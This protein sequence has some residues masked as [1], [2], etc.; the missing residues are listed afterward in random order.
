MPSISTHLHFGKVLLE[1]NKDIDLLNFTIGLVAPETIYDNLDDYH[2]LDEDGNIDVREFY[3]K[4]N[5]K[6]LSLEA[7]SFILGYYSNLWLEEYYKFNA[8]KL[9]VHNK[10]ELSDE[11]LIKAL[12]DTV[13]YYDTNAIGNFFDKI[14][15][16]IN[17]YKFNINEIQYINIHEAKSLLN[18]YFNQKYPNKSHNELI[19]EH[20]Y[21]SFISKSCNKFLKSL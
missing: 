8:S 20:E 11:E 14:K 13:R 5:F 17:N 2:T 18:D 15:N 6:N 19:D 9:T 12:D 7:K 10:E 4:F 16:S 21:I 3:E 1:N